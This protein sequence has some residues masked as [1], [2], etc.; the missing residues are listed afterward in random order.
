[1]EGL[2]E[3]NDQNEPMA[4]RLTATLQGQKDAAEIFYQKCAKLFTEIGLTQCVKDPCLYYKLGDKFE[5]NV[6]VLQ[7]VDDFLITGPEG[8]TMDSVKKMLRDK[9]HCN[10]IAEATEFLSIRI[11]RDRKQKVIYIDQEAQID[12][13][14]TKYQ[15]TDCKPKDTPMELGCQLSKQQECTTEFNY[16]SCIPSL[17]YVVMGT[18]P[19][20]AHAVG[21]LCRHVKNP[22]EPHAKAAKRVLRYLKGTKGL[23]L[24][25]G[26]TRTGTHVELF[27]DSDHASNDPDNRKST[28]GLALYIGEDIIEWMSRLQEIIASSTTFAEYIA[29]HTGLT[30][31]I[32]WTEFLQ[33]LNM[34]D[35]KPATVHEDNQQCIRWAETNMIN[36]RNRAVEIKYHRI[37]EYVNNGLMKMKYIETEKQIADILTKPLG[38][39]VF[40]RH[41][42]MLNVVQP[43]QYLVDDIT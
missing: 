3:Y 21:V 25:I 11:T 43:P 8:E 28:T 30:G 7:Y 27:A 2:P 5:N 16:Q 6:Y 39:E 38:R 9:L 19:D 13:V 15:M 35:G 14:L 23:R 26:G 40:Q 17:L 36:Q 31:I 24:K 34:H 10:S 33:L 22:G 18:R 41:R 37:R 1:M 4:Y 42:D 32:H 20:I 12:K 29:L